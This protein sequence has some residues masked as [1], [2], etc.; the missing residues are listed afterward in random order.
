MVADTLN[1]A[2]RAVDPR[3]GEVRTLMGDGTPFDAA[4]AALERRPALPDDV[5]V[6]PC[7]REPEAVAWD[8]ERLLVV[9][10]GNHR[11]L[12]VDPATGAATVLAGAATV[13]AGGAEP[14]PT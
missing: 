10:T 5:R 12:A 1:H 14:P 13:L 3:S 6:R 9:D 8:G 11:V 4:L 7:C 2:V